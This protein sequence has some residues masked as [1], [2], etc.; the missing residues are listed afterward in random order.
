M[1]LDGEI[2]LKINGEREVYRK[3]DTYFIP[4]DIPH[5]AKIKAG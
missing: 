2:E 4:K 5:S 1:V 3:G